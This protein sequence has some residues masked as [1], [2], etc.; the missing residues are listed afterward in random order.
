MT[1]PSFLIID[2]DSEFAESVAT[3]LLLRG[4][5][6]NYAFSGTDALKLLEKDDSVDVVILDVGM[7]DPDGL[8]TLETIKKKHPLVEVIMLT[9]QSDVSSAVESLKTGAFE[10][11]MKPCDLDDLIAK[12]EQAFSRKKKRE[13]EILEV[14]MKPYLTESERDRLTA[15]IL[16]KE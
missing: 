13:A 14:R 16:G 1:T 10:Y 5:S 2:D 4:F 11:L 15:R 3:R 6:A 12:A 9:G 8:K 7:P